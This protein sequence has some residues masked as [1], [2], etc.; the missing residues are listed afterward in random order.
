MFYI[1]YIIVTLLYF[2][3]GILLS[4]FLFPTISNKEL[5]SVPFVFITPYDVDV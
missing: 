1:H 5:R 3:V 4:A 2:L